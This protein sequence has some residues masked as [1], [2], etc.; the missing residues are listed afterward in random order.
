MIFNRALR[1]PKHTS[2]NVVRD[3]ALYGVEDLWPNGRRKTLGLLIPLFNSYQVM[4]LAVFVPPVSHGRRS[5][6]VGLVV[7]SVV[8]LHLPL[9]DFFTFINFN[10]F[11]LLFSDVSGWH[12]PPPLLVSFPLGSR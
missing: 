12:P 8:G 6:R 11:Y 1:F 3:R 5:S 4:I 2:F 9:A 7:L 10:L